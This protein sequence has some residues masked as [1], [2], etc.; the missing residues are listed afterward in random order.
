MTRMHNRCI[1]LLVSKPSSFT[2]HPYVRFTDQG[3]S[4]LQL[5]SPSRAYS[6]S[7]LSAQNS[8]LVQAT[9]TQQTKHKDQSTKTTK[10]RLDLRLVSPLRIPSLSSPPKAFLNSGQ[11]PDPAVCPLTL[12]SKQYGSPAGQ[13][14]I[15]FEDSPHFLQV[16]TICCYMII[17]PT[18]VT[19]YHIHPLLNPTPAKP[20]PDFLFPEQ[21][22]HLFT[23][24][25]YRHGLIS[26]K[27]W[28]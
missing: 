28:P 12:Q 3:S 17:A 1:R 8:T 9:S 10:E 5:P 19:L 2:N 11:L 25:S 14:Q 22:V 13:S 4:R 26:A 15:L 7:H 20:D 6:Y 27:I 16:L 23:T 18:L 24:K 21:D